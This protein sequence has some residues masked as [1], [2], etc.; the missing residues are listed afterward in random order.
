MQI[1]KHA[2]SEMSEI[3]NSKELH[4]ST[5]FYSMKLFPM[6]VWVNNSDTVC[7]YIEIEHVG[8]WMEIDGGQI[9]HCGSG[10]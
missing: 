6:G 2:N 7:I 3:Y 4:V 1:K 10:S 8:K 5:I 9:S